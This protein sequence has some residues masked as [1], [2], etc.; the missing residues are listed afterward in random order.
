MR[1]AMNWH[2]SRAAEDAAT[3]NAGAKREG[4]QGLILLEE[5]AAD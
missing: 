3:Q 4:K 5:A 2:R 1:G